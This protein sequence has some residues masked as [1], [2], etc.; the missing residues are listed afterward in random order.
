MERIHS[1]QLEDV[2]KN[3]DPVDVTLTTPQPKASDIYYAPALRWT[4]TI[5]A[6]RD[7]WTLRGSYRH[8]NEIKGKT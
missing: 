1:H 5:Y 2:S 4:D 3:A 7:P 6:N 8:M